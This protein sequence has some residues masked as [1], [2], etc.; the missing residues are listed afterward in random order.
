M[1]KASS[2][3]LITT[4]F[5]FIPQ[6]LSSCLVCFSNQ[7]KKV[8]FQS[9]LKHFFETFQPGTLKFEGLLFLT[10]EEASEYP[11]PVAEEFVPRTSS[12]ET[13]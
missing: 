5:S 8:V 6:P 2:H 7:L 10:C 3:D 11:N 1:T 9:L 12:A 4:F 13:L